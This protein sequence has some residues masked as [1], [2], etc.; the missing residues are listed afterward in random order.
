MKVLSIV[1]RN[2]IYFGQKGKFYALNGVAK[3]Q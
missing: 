1:N 3:A 2:S